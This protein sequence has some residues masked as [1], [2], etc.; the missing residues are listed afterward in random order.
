MNGSDITTGNL[1]VTDKAPYFGLL[2]NAN[3]DENDGKNKSLATSK[4]DGSYQIREQ[5]VFSHFNNIGDKNPRLVTAEDFI[6]AISTG[7]INDYSYKELIL[8]IRSAQEQNERSKLKK[9]LPAVTLSSVCVGGHRKEDIQNLTGFLQIDIDKLQNVDEIK[10]RLKQDRHIYLLFLSPSGNGLKCVIN[11]GKNQPRIVF[12]YVRLY[13]K[14]KYSLEIDTQVKDESR[15]CFYSY[16]PDIYVN[17]D[18][19]EFEYKAVRSLPI[20]RKHTSEVERL[21][22]RIEFA[23]H[24]ITSEH[25]DWIMLAFAL[26]NAFGIDGE[27]YFHRL[28]QFYPD[29]NYNE[30]S[31]QYHYCLNAGSKAITIKSLILFVSKKLE[32]VPFQ[33]GIPK[34]EHQ[35]L[36]DIIFYSPTYDKDGNLKDLKIDYIKWIEVLYRLGFRRFDMDKNFV[37]VRIVDQIIEEVSVTH[38]QDAFINYL[39]NLPEEV[40]NGISREFLI[41][42]FYR[43][44]P[45]YFCDNRLSL[46]R[47]KEPLLF[48]KDSKDNCRI[49]FKNGFV[50]CSSNGYQ[51][52]SYS[53]MNGLIWKNQIV[54]R[55]FVFL[56]FILRTPSDRGVFSMFIYN[57]CGKDLKRYESLTTI[58]GYLLHSHFLGKLKA[59]VFTDSKISDVPC[60]RTGKTLVGQA[61]AFIKNYIELNGKDFDPT[62]KHKYQEVNLDTQI[63]HVN[64]L[65]KNFDFENL[66]NDITEG[67][68]VDKK[69]IQP[70][71][72][73]A[74][75]IISTN[76]TI[77]IEGDSALDRAIEFEFSN[78]YN[79]NFSPEDELHHWFFR[80]WDKA[81]WMKFFNFFLFCIC[82]YLKNGVINAVPVNLNRRKLRENTSQ[83]F[84]EFMDS[85]VKDGEIKPG[86]EYDKKVLFDHFLIDSPEYAEVKRFKQSRFT[87]WLRVYAKYSGNFS[88]IDPDVNERKSGTIRYIIFPPI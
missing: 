34:S 73:M 70:F 16:D 31:K 61:L 46:L 88:A 33:N 19:A 37:F 56:D 9:S 84:E 66:F 18:K 39:E 52:L 14:E 28:S 45:H 48:S 50:L 38:I 10:E 58:M 71:K 42:K 60:G 49:Y 80:D 57:V 87:E 4:I 65:K 79:A 41:G 78:H 55:N 64:D 72:V 75:I 25:K 69:N 63:V 15:L 81:E 7:K 22:T 54:D 13:F 26:V 5:I 77:K 20:Q 1:L 74:K 11:I 6:A 40:S 23:K 86:I 17:E 76:K 82:S 68:V 47:A 21:I 67:I 35:N 62:N 30:C 83:E 59:V 43:Q 12:E 32:K 27:N 24:D 2:P 44:P 3:T 85:Q 51:L 29:Y 36:E 53:L 8:K